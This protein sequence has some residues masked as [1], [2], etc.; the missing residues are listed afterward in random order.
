MESRLRWWPGLQVAFG[1]PEALLDLEQLVVGADHELR[2]DG[3]AIGAGPQVS[4]VALQPG[5]G[6]GLVLQFPV[7]GAGAAGQPDEPVALHRGLP[8]DGLLG[9]GDLLV[10]AAQRAAGPVSLVYW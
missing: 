2:G 8:R 4:D 9:L 7:D 10:D 6:A 3:R 5:Q 1:H